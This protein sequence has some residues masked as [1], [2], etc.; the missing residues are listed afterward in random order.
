MK[1]S[2]VK[3]LG[4]GVAVAALCGSSVLMAMAGGSVITTGGTV[5]TKNLTPE[6]VLRTE[7]GAK[8]SSGNQNLYTITYDY[9][10]PNY[11]LVLGNKV[12]GLSKVTNMAKNLNAQDNYTV[13]AGVNGDHF[14]YSTGIPMGF[15]MDDGRIVESPVADKNAD[16]YMFNAIG[17]TRDGKAVAGYNPT[18]ISTLKKSGASDEDRMSIDRINRTR[19]SFAPM[20]LYTEDYGTS[21]HTKSGGIELR[22]KVTSGGVSPQ[23]NPLVGTIEAISTDGNLAITPGTVVLSAEGSRMVDL[24]KFAQGDTVEMN[25]AFLQ[26]E[27]NDVDFAIGGHYAIVQDGKAMEL[28]YDA[29]ANPDGDGS[30]FDSLA[31]RTGFGITKD[32]KVVIIA[33][34][35]R[36]AGGGK[37]FN[38]NEMARY[39]AEDLNCQYAILLDGGGSTAMVT[40]NGDTPE[41]VNTPSDKDGS[42]NFGAERS[43]GN[44]LFVVKLDTPRETTTPTEGTKPIYDEPICMLPESLDGA[45]TNGLTAS[46]EGETLKLVSTQDK[47]SITFNLDKEYNINKLPN[48]F[49]NVEAGV[50]FDMQ[51]NYTGKNASAVGLISDFGP[52]FGAG[53]STG[54]DFIPAGTYTTDGKGHVA[55]SGGPNYNSNVPDNGK[56]TINSIT[57]TLKNPGTLLVN[58]MYM[59]KL[60]AQEVPSHTTSTAKPTTSTDPVITTSSDTETTGTEP[61]TSGSTADNDTTA[62]SDSTTTTAASSDTSATTTTASQGDSPKTGE[63]AAAVAAASALA[64]L[65]ASGIYLCRKMKKA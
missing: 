37:G 60:E 32:G 20:A 13:V 10:D 41:V 47:A 30:P 51:F 56:I 38:A 46:Y 31:S 16:G 21:T 26:E 18:L 28:D 2:L 14:S 52:D 11:D 61:T 5:T 8:S 25:F 44:G 49:F 50:G 17:I 22:V 58:T 55:F 59:A 12:Y 29:V 65:S 27:W 43:V 62:S 42:G 15:S 4:I 24:K 40:M 35:G 64:L 9:S 53:T 36:N 23:A 39:M 1:N 19:E 7:K 63:G 54:T 6:V 34:D 57:I 33:T 45:A 48:L 3:K